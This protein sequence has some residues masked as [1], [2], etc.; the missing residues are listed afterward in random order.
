M[1]LLRVLQFVNVRHAQLEFP[2]GDHVKDVGATPL[3]LLPR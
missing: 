3:K 1:C 2:G